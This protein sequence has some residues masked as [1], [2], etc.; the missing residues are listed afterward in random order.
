RIKLFEIAGMTA[1]EAAFDGQPG[2][3]TLGRIEIAGPYN[4]TGVSETPSRKR[5]F[6]CRPKVASEE[7]PCATT[8]LS[9][10]VRRAFRRDISAADLKPFL[11]TY[12][13]TREKH[14]FDDAIAAAIR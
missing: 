3:P 10:I 9:T 4:P 12:H 5:I 8:I 6:T 1:G 14:G 2:P 7:T 13:A 11:A